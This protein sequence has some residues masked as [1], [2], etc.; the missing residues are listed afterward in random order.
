MV[1]TLLPLQRRRSESSERFS[2]SPV[3]QDK[4]TGNKLRL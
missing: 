1:G 4:L 3:G 2:L